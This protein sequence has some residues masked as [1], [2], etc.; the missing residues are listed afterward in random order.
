VSRSA[1]W[2]RSVVDQRVVADGCIV[3]DDTYVPMGVQLFRDVV[4]D[5]PTAAEVPGD[6]PAAVRDATSSDIFRRVGGFFNRP[7]WSRPAAQ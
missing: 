6:A 5:S 1:I 7:V 3:A 2:R 4:A